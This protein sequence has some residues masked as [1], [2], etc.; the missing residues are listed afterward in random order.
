MCCNCFV[1][2]C[3]SGAF[4]KF[5]FSDAQLWWTKI[6]AQWKSAKGNMRNNHIPA[7]GTFDPVSAQD[8]CEEAL[9]IAAAPC[10]TLNMWCSARWRWGKGVEMHPHR[11]SSAQICG[12]RGRSVT[13]SRFVSATADRPRFGALANR[14]L[15]HSPK[16]EAALALLL[17]TGRESK[18]N[19]PLSGD[20]QRR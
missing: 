9:L 18:N 12:P 6:G 8:Q 15:G 5:S 17:L 2:C 13:N 1:V 19:L 16:R 11:F 14:L 4:P 3:V 20:Q 7:R 10:S